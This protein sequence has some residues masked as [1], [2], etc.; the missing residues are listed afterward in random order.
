M[1]P[2]GAPDVYSVE[3][4]EW[5]PVGPQMSTVLSILSRALWGVVWLLMEE[6]LSIKRVA[7]NVLN[8]QSQT[9]DKGWSSSLFLGEVL[10][11][12]H[13]SSLP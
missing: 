1:G 3:Y 2:C 6:E 11:S 12:H 8:K 4:T 7:A 9:D 13:H 5:G 10:T